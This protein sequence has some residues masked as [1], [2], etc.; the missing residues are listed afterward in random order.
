MQL[1][2]YVEFAKHA[3]ESY[4]QNTPHTTSIAATAWTDGSVATPEA[5]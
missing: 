5:P 1:L 3:F 4:L 2:N